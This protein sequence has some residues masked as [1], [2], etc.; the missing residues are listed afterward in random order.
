MLACQNCNRGIGGKSDRVPSVKLLERLNR[1][2]EFLIDSHHP[3]RETLMLQTGTTPADRIKFL[4]E[5][6]RHAR[7]HLIHQWEPHESFTP[8]F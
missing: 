4:N 5:F 7:S 6:H 3:L 2:N 1:R 8:A